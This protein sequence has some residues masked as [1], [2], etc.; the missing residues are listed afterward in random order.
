LLWKRAVWVSI[1]KE[2]KKKKKKKKRELLSD[3]FFLPDL[4]ARTWEVLELGAVKIPLFT[5][6]AW[7]ILISQAM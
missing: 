5:L 6:E 3:A 2:K 7:F 1:S 4:T